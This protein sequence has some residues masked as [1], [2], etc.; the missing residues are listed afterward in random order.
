M[1]GFPNTDLAVHCVNKSATIADG[2]PFHPQWLLRSYV[3]SLWC[4]TCIY[5]VKA[6]MTKLL[7]ASQY[8][9]LPVFNFLFPSHVAVE[10][11][12][13]QPGCCQSIASKES[14]VASIS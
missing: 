14:C 13:H 8:R 11:I 9:I 1:N 6:I 7:P 12:R 5:L 3:V 10:S 2:C 4:S